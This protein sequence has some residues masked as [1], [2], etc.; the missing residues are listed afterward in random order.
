MSLFSLFVSSPSLNL[1][2]EGSVH[3]E[4]VVQH[5][6]HLQATAEDA[7]LI[8]IF[9]ANIIVATMGSINFRANFLSVIIGIPI[10]FAYFLRLML[11]H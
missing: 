7:D 1:S 2:S 8:Y 6:P 3:L 4:Q 10:S 9:E 11:P 5:S